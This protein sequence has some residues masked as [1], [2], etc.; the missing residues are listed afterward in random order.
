M[1]ETIIAA[2]RHSARTHWPAT[3]VSVP[4]GPSGMTRLHALRRAFGLVLGIVASSFPLTPLSLLA[5]PL[6]VVII[7][8]YGV[9]R[10]DRI[11]LA[12]GCCGLVLIALAV[13]MVS[14]TSAWLKLRRQGAPRDLLDFEAGVPFRTGYRTAQIAW[15]PLIKLEFGWEQ[16]GGVEVNLVPSGTR[17]LEEVKAT[18]RAIA[19]EIVRRFT[20]ADVLG[21]ASFTIRRRLA[22]PVAIQPYR[23]RVG[24]IELVQ[25][26][27]PG[28]E[29]G[30]PEGKPE[31]DLIDMRRYSAGDPLRLVLWK[32]YARTGRM[33]V[34]SPERAVMR[35][36]K[37]LVYFVAGAD[38]E[39]SAGV[40]RALLEI[41]SLGTD[42]WFRADGQAE[43]TRDVRNAIDQVIRS[44]SCRDRGGEGLGKFLG[45]GE[46][47]GITACILFVPARPGAWLERVVE[48]LGRYPGPFRALIGVDGVPSASMSPRPLR[49]LLFSAGKTTSTKLNDLC[50]VC[51]RLAK[52]NAI[53]CVVDRASGMTFQLAD[54]VATAAAASRSANGGRS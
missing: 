42:F 35:S 8:V 45:R 30:H 10:N 53:V 7:K 47:L 29:V 19:G 27:V 24:R 41:G 11:I 21:L 1:I 54:L 14:V 17:F 26:Y 37:T 20:V 18:E 43:S 22:Q 2:Q 16:P 34:R 50:H 25:Q 4:T 5:I 44:S 6:L 51:D 33:L 36:Q 40:T 46:E 31:G 9:G 32:V 52:V 3:H 38:D 39:A 15:I 12:L 23:G 13:I 49:K 28:D 48:Q